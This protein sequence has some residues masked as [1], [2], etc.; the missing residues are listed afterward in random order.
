MTAAAYSLAPLIRTQS[1][2][3]RSAAPL[4][5]FVSFVALGVPTARVATIAIRFCHRKP[6][7]DDMHRQH[8]P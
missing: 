4:K 6:N 2:R 7:C 8:V 1:N 5:L 3:S